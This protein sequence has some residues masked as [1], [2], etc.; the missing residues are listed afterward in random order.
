MSCCSMVR[1]RS[2]SLEQQA[3][4]S[5]L[6]ELDANLLLHLALGHRCGHTTA[7]LHACVHVCVLAGVHPERGSHSVV[8]LPCSHVCMCSCVVWD[9]GCRN[10]KTGSPRALW[11]GLEFI[12]FTLNRCWSNTRSSARGSGSDN[13][14]SS[15]DS[16]GGS[17][18]AGDGGWSS[19]SSHLLRAHIRGHD[20][21]RDFEAAC[22]R[23]VWVAWVGGAQVPL[24]LHGADVQPCV[25]LP[26]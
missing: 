26:A 20:V 25:A 4:E 24:S 18:D 23:C 21:S 19:G 2:T 9:T 6:L 8:T 22:R 12:R 3:F 13:G 10:R 11:Y 7:G 1:I 16:S 15:A 14:S 17:S 5:L